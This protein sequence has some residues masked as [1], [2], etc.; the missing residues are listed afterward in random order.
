[1]KKFLMAVLLLACSNEKAE[2]ERECEEIAT[3]IR[4]AAT[5]RGLNTQG[6]CSNPNPQ[7]QKDFGPACARLKKC[8]EEASQL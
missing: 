6:V 7:V 1:M 5:A 3:E 4:E 8:N 2:K